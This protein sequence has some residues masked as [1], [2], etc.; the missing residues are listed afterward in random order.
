[1]EQVG[2]V[3]TL[4]RVV[5]EVNEVGK[6]LSVEKRERVIGYF[7]KKCMNVR[8]K[9]G[10]RNVLKNLKT[11]DMMNTYCCHVYAQKS[12]FIAENCDGFFGIAAPSPVSLDVR[13]GSQLKMKQ[14]F[15]GAF[16]FNPS[17]RFTFSITY[18]GGKFT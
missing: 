17:L 16:P 10:T 6:I 13:V 5:V 12:L 15:S 8:Q 2:E 1:M 18:T 7:W 4:V 3:A 14:E 9:L 11:L